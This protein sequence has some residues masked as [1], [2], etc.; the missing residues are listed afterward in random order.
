LAATTAL[1]FCGCASQSDHG[2]S[3]TAAW[4]LLFDGKTTQGWHTFKTQ[5]FPEKG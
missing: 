3:T 2:K 1:L 4:K 5:S